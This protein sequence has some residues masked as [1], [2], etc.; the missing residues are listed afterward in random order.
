MNTFLLMHKNIEVLEIRKEP[1]MDYFQIN[2]IINA[3]HLPVNMLGENK[4]NNHELNQFLKHR[5]IPKSRPNIEEIKK[6]YRANSS[7]ELA[8]P[9][10]MVSIADHYWLCP[11]DKKQDLNW[12]KVNFYDNDFSSDLLFLS[13]DESSLD[14][15][16]RMNPTPNTTNNGSLPQMWT[17]KDSD[18]FFI[19]NGQRSFYQQPYNEAVISDMM[20]VM[21]MPG[22]TYDLSYI[23]AADVS[24]CPSFT[25]SRIEFIPAWQFVVKPKL[26]HESY[27]EYYLKEITEFGMD[28]ER[29]RKQ[30]EQMIILDFICVNEDRHWGNF[31]VLRDSDTL[32]Y[33]GL[34]PIFDNGSSLGYMNLSIRNHQLYERSKSFG[35]THQKEL[36][37]IRH[38]DMDSLDICDKIPEILDRNYKKLRHP[39]FGE[40]RVEE[41]AALLVERIHDMGKRKESKKAAIRVAKSIEEKELEPEF[42]EKALPKDLQQDIQN[43]LDHQDDDLRWDVY[44]N[45]LYGTINMYQHAHVIS[46]EVADYLRK[47]Y[48][49]L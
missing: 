24:I 45:E 11:E 20:K 34:A 27:Y 29:A 40:E 18:L 14:E 13:S 32:E 49:G 39:A 4:C 16:E 28:Q 22:V 42:D 46:E 10:Y 2:A 21:N 36:K 26:N 5:V 38:M 35:N 6:Y 19:K 12:E 43:W 1:D 8:L 33:I 41:I 3:E 44:H 9:S 25:N 23:T 17:K 37:Y 15:S 7:Y 31:G 30:L 47:K 48:L